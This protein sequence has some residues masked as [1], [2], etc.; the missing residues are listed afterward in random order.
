MTSDKAYDVER[1]LNNLI[2]LLFPG[3]Y[4][5]FTPLANGWALGG[6]WAKVRWFPGNLV[7]VTCLAATAGTAVDGTQFATIPASDANGNGLRPAQQVILTQGINIIRVGTLAPDT[8]TSNPSGVY[9]SIT[10]AGNVFIH[11]V[12]AAASFLAI[13]GWYPTDTM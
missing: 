13:H 8:V 10:A 7:F 3:P 2:P 1:R 5:A 4:T 6:G 11:G 12:A 9:V